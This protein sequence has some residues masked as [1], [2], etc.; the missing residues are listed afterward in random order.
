MPALDEVSIGHAVICD[1]LYL[2]IAET[3]RRYRA[4]LK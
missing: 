1:A 2:G 3:L 4:C